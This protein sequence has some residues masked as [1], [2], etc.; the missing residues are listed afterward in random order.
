MIG[1]VLYGTVALV[2]AAAAF[3]LAE[4][5]RDPGTPAPDN[6]GVLA[7]AAGLIWPVLIIGA[8]Q[9]AAIAAVR[10]RVRVETDA[11]VP[12]GAGSRA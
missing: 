2:F 3:L 7:I 12:I 11:R 9:M 10:T 1:I 8:L 4:W 5:M 6:P